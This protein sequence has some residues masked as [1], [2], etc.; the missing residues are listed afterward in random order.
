MIS[1]QIRKVLL[2][3]HDAHPQM[4]S[5]AEKA[6]LTV[7]SACQDLQ[8]RVGWISPKPGLSLDRAMRMGMDAKVVPFPLLWSLIHDPNRLAEELNLLRQ[9]AEDGQLDRAI[10]EYSPDLIVS[11]S[12]IN[13]LP[14]MIAHKRKLPVWWYIHEVIPNSGGIGRFLSILRCHADRILVPSQAAKKSISRENG[15][16]GSPEL[17]PYGVEIPSDSLVAGNRQAARCQN[18]W[19]DNHV[20][21]GWFGSIY[22]GKGLLELIRAAADLRPEGKA[23]V[24]LAAGNV[25]DPGYFHVCREEAERIGSVEFRYLGVLPRIEEILP[26]ADLVAVP[27]LVEEA[28]PNVALEAMA[29]GKSVVAY[30]SGGLREMVVHGET[31]L[32]TARGD[33]VALASSIR[34]LAGD[35]AK[36]EEMGRKGR[37]RAAM[38]Y[39]MELF[40]TRIQKMIR[41]SA[42]DQS[43]DRSD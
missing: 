13:G 20:V 40:K 5:G 8:V 24:L 27:S 10:A 11:N 31:G 16:P 1:V 33:I 34:D 6:L 41:Q 43:R 26:A 22:H 38:R 12:A 37:E 29:F 3:S 23:A 32:L 39:G 14:T 36:R 19:T 17:L 9:A 4:V 18:G 2:V 30:E 21:V 25:V 42:N 15:S 35:S 28:F 7:G